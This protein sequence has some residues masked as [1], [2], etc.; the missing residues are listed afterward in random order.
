ML[1]AGPNSYAKCHIEPDGPGRYAFTYAPLEVG[2]FTVMLKWNNRELAG[3]PYRVRVRAD[4]TARSRAALA[5]RILAV[6]AV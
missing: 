2:Q 6:V 3:S 4:V 5:A 1:D